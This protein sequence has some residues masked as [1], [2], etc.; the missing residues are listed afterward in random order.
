MNG[1][2]LNEALNLINAQRQDEYG[3]P[4]HQKFEELN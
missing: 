3:P 2:I 1:T 4:S